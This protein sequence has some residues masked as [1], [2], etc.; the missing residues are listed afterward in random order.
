MS[1][2]Q[3]GT[4]RVKVFAGV[5]VGDIEKTIQQWLSTNPNF[6]LFFFAQS[7]GDTHLLTNITILY[8]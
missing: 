8:A 6:T 5:L 4:M 3:G 1:G 2:K 7:Q